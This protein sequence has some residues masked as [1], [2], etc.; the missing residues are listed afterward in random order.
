[1]ASVDKHYNP[2][3]ASRLRNIAGGRQ[4]SLLPDFLD[5]LSN[6]QFRTAGYILGEEIMPRLEA[7]DFWLLTTLLYKYNAKAFLVTCMKSATKRVG[8]YRREDAEELWKML[9]AND[10]DATKTLQTLLPCIHDDVHTAQHLLNVMVGEDAEK[11]IALLLKIDTPVGAYLLLHA[12]RQVE[13]NRP[14]LVRTTYFLIKRG[15]PLSFNLASLFKA[16]F[17][18]EEVRGTFSLRLQP[19]ELSRLETSYSAFKA[20]VLNAL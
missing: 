14:L 20:R 4:W 11:R 5:G 8:E 6:A 10:I 3:I 16:F 18:L 15:D 2:I 12:L 13:H 19:F 9:S 1:M 17:G 7:E